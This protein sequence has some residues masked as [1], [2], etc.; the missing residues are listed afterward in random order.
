[1][2]ASAQTAPMTNGTCRP[3]RNLDHRSPAMRLAA[4]WPQPGD[5]VEQADRAGALIFRNNIAD[6]GF[7]HASVSA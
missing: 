7:C 5:R 1:M 2:A 3:N 4:N 6:Q